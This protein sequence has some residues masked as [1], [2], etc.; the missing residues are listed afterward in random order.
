MC[1]TFLK[2]KWLILQQIKWYNIMT[3]T[4]GDWEM[5]NR[6]LYK[7]LTEE[8]IA[9][10]QENLEV[11]DALASERTLMQQTQMSR[12]TIRLAMKELET[13]GYIKTEHG[14]G[15][16]VVNKEINNYNLAGMYSFSEHMKLLGHNPTTEIITT[17]I[18]EADSP[19][20]KNM[21]LV[22][23]PPLVHFKRVRLADKEPMILEDT[24]LP[25]KSFPGIEKLVSNTRGLYEVLQTD[26]ETIIKKAEDEMFARIAEEETADF[27]N[28]QSGDP[29]IEILRKTYDTKNNLIEFTHSFA[30]SDKFSYRILHTR[31]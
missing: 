21:P 14:R 28:I 22:I 25:Q 13:S 31:E 8:L 18:L 9:Y 17:E 24:Y 7:Q 4:R 29:V 19:L 26:F 27:L 12:T 2:N 30:R 6:P 15:R 1:S 5:D 23:S 11:G 20:L 10:I 3:I 16:F